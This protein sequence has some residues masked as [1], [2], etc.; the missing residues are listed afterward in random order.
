M[1]RRTPLFTAAERE[2]LIAFPDSEDELYRR[3][4]FSAP[5]LSIRVSLT[6]PRNDN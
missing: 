2:K 6:K 4:M 3:Y 5:Y 1:P